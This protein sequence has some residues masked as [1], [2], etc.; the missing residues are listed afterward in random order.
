MFKRKNSKIPTRLP[1]VSVDTSLMVFP[2]ISVYFLRGGDLKTIASFVDGWDVS[3]DNPWVFL[4]MHNP[5]I[6]SFPEKIYKTGMVAKV[7]IDEKRGD[8]IFSGL[9]R[10]KIVKLKEV[11]RN[12]KEKRKTPFLFAEIKYFSDENYD[13]AFINAELSVR[14]ALLALRKILSL[15]PKEVYEI[16]DLGIKNLDFR[17]KDAIDSLI[18]SILYSL[19]EDVGPDERQVFLE[20]DNLIERLEF[21]IRLTRK[22]LE[23]ISIANRHL[24]SLSDKLKNKLSKET[25]KNPENDSK[26]LNQN[27]DQDDPDLESSPEI[28]KKW[29]KY[30]EIKDKLSSDAQAAILEDFGRLK[31]CEPRQS[32][33]HTFINHLDCLLGLYSAVL[34]SPEEDISKVEKKLDES[35][36]GLEDLKEEIYNHLAVKS[37]NP[38]NKAPILCFVGPPGVGKSSIGKSIAESLGLK[39]IRLSLGGIRDEAEIRGHRFTY[40]GSIPGKIIHEIVRAGVANPVFMLDEIDKLGNDFRGDPSSALLEVLDPEQNH[41]FSDHYVGAPYDLSN[42]LFLCTANTVFGIQPALLDRMHVVYVSGY[43]EFQKI[44]IAKK[45]LFPKQFTEMGLTDKGIK[46]SWENNNPD[47]VISKIISGYTR[48]AGVRNLERQIHKLLSI[49]V[50]QYLKEEEDERSS[51]IL[52]TERL[53][54]NFLGSSWFAH[55]RINVTEIGESI[56]LAWTPVGGM[57][58]YIQ[59]QLTPCGRTKKDISQTGGM[60]EVF[61]EANKIALTVVKNLLK[62]NDSIMKKL[63]DNLLH[64]SVPGGAIKKDG[65]S[66][67]ITMAMAIYSELTERPLKPYVA[68]S[69][70]I[71]IKGRI[72]AV[73]GLKEKV[74]AAHRDGVKEI[75]LPASNKENIDREIPQEVKQDVKFHFVTNIKEVLPIVFP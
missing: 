38:K 64:L 44:Q 72:L 49:W 8:I 26:T 29:Q 61:M 75:I 25:E 42:V 28:F 15:Y 10:A 53:I 63:K 59:A 36:H 52:I 2:G 27:D 17:D 34:I 74:L 70:E 24:H 31:N 22:H 3:K 13:E 43:T 57:I 23:I 65:P 32:E 45:F 46:L 30:K 21:L 73:G 39:F 66:A 1:V 4:A 12:E 33:W 58:M 19:P 7:E 69:G 6:E 16:Y 18:W 67:G 55:E 40:V 60:L 50:R 51:E 56:G 41:S 68:M 20:S 14:G 47:Q 37:L 54:D 11:F 62:D 48:E 9:C 35:H 71:T 5:K